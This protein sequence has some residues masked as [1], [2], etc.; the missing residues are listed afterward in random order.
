METVILIF[1]LI[2]VVTMVMVILLQRNSNDGLSGLGGGS[3]NPS[4]LGQTRGTANPLTKATSILATLFV[5]TSLSLA[6]LA[7]AKNV[8]VLDDEESTISEE[9]PDIEE[10]KSVPF[11]LDETE[12]QENLKDGTVPVEPKAAAEVEEKAEEKTAPVSE[13]SETTPAEVPVAE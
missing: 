12:V 6:Y 7:N 1:H 10:S 5:G 8:S 2:I 4:A 13:T 11:L 9:I 3:S